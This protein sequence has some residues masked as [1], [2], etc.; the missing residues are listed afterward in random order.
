MFYFKKLSAV[1]HQRLTPV[2]LATQEAEIRRIEIQSQP[3]QTGCKTLS[4]GKKKN[5][6]KNVEWP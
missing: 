1:R 2:I 3:G 5:L 6:H 4:W